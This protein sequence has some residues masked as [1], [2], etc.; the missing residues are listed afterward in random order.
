MQVSRFYGR[1]NCSLSR[2]KGIQRGFCPDSS[3]FGTARIHIGIYILRACRAYLPSC[4]IDSALARVSNGCAAPPTPLHYGQ[5][6]PAC[7]LALL[8]E[9]PAAVMLLPG[10]EFAATLSDTLP[11]PPP[12]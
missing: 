6:V 8:P 7:P 12:T 3:S 11:P 2:K 9:P 4:L 10:M 1:G 5:T